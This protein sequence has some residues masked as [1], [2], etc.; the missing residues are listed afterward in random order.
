MLKKLFTVLIAILTLLASFWPSPLW[1]Q[2]APASNLLALTGEINTPA[3]KTANKFGIHI[4]EPS[5]LKRASELVNSTGG[6]WGW[7]T[8]VIREDDRDRDKWQAFFDQCRQEHLIPIVRIATKIE[9]SGW[10]KPRA[11]QA[12]EWA[13]FLASLN[14][15]TKDQYVTVF[16]EPN[17][18][19]EWGGELNPREYSRILAEFIAR[20]KEKNPHFKLLNGGLDLAAPN[21]RETMDAHRYLSQMKAEVPDIFE[22]LDGWCSHSYPN[23]GFVG[24][25]WETGRVSVKGYDW[26]LWV[27]RNH[28]GLQKELPVYITETGWPKNSPRYYD[29]ITTAT[30]LKNAFESVWLN[31]TRVMAVTPFVLNYPQELFMAFSWLDDQGRPYPQYEL[32]KSMPKS[33][34]WP[35]QINRY[36][37]KAVSLPSFLPAN[38]TYEGKIVLK[39]IGQSIWGDKEPLKV[40]VQASGGLVVSGLVLGSQDTIEPGETEEIRFTIKSLDT[41]GEYQFA[42]GELPPQQIEVFPASFVY[43]ARYNLWERLMIKVKEAFL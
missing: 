39:N 3:Q 13:D 24:K 30:Y 11:E 5:D 20:F 7:V 1:A 9:G 43:Q 35:E 29:E 25:P 15:P 41:P 36:Q 6:D 21:G 31:D 27:L 42:W 4:L 14:W 19:K 23:H 2:Q 26:E 28:F 32:V 16:N 8:V 37:V 34:W 38:T 22:R 18:A 33:S 40:P 10:A 12:R 17:H